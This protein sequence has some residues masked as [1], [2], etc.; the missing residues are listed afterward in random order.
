MPAEP[1]RTQLAPHNEIIQQELATLLALEEVLVAEST[2]LRQ[3]DY[4]A[5]DTARTLKEEL[6][7]RLHELQ[8]AR[9]SLHG[10]FSRQ[11]REQHQ[12]LCKRISRLAEENGTRL[13]ASLDAVQ[14][15]I[16]RLTGRS[17]KSGSGYGRKVVG[18]PKAANPVLTSTVG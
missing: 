3:L 17:G 12:T 16:D 13:K 5:I 14:D 10:E 18:G 2:A 15:L 9:K 1:K 11:D 8:D 7:E 6:D 4:D